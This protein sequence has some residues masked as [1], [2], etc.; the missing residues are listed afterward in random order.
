MK[1]ALTELTQL[2]A[3]LCPAFLL[4]PDLPLAERIKTYQIA[5]LPTLILYRDRQEETRWSG[6]FD[7]PHEQARDQM[8]AVLLS[9][10]DRGLDL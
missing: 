6:F 1:R 2:E 4:D 7:S 8:R 5:D 3:R 10:L 9:A